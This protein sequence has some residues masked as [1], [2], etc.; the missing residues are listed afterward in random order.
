MIASWMSYAALVGALISVAAAAL[1]RVAAVQ[2]RQRRFIWVAAMAAALTWP[3]A[4]AVRQL[5]PRPVPVSTLLPFT[6]TVQPVHVAAGALG[7][8]VAI[9][10]DRALIAVWIA[11]SLLV[12]GRIVRATL[13]MRRARDGWRTGQV[14]GALVRL[15]T[16]VGPAVVGLR[17]MDVVLPEWVLS[18]DDALRAIVLCHEQ[19][20]RAARDPYLLYFAAVSVALMPWN[21]ALWYAA[22][23]L[24]L[25]I[26]LD[27]D[28]RVLR[29]H[30]SP[31]TYGMLMLA[32]A[33]RRTTSTPLFAALLSE[34]A[35]QLERRILAMRTS[36]TRVV[37]ATV[38]G[39]ALVAAGALAVAC[40]LQSDTATAPKPPGNRA[41][42]M[43]NG[44]T[45]FFEFQVDE[46]AQVAPGNPA[47]R[48]PDILRTAGVNG[49]VLAQFVVGPDGR[50]DMNTFK[51]LRSN[52]QL[53]TTAVMNAVPDMR[54]TPG[55]I[56]GKPVKQLVQMPFQFQLAPTRDTGAAKPF[57]EF[58][59]GKQA[60]PL[61]TTAPARYP[62]ELRAE[63]V[64]GEVLAQFVVG[65][66]GVPDTSSF[67]VLRSDHVLFARAV[68]AALPTMRFTPAETEDGHKVRQL[69]RMPFSFKLA[70]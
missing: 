13:A 54:F 11:L 40:S 53:F 21:P 29:A 52:N 60:L 56:A 3:V 9:T 42:L 51:V 17:T 61:P 19:E 7:S 8:E 59:L 50:P 48:Y 39:G 18:L 46:P 38:T 24:R 4:S 28:A 6:V 16:D 70:K 5:V 1:D 68:K 44:T 55:R 31:E 62:D 14:D 33:Q 30:P 25:A 47:P 23:R 10:I 34:P 65:A 15:S 12:L 58:K 43:A 37:R 66:D 22:R 26:E 49:E 2:A 20:H 64:Q 57:F 32:I 41:A 27:C 67:M 36:S 69:V 45:T 63:K 35:T